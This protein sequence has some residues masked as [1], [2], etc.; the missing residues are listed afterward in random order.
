MNWCILI[1]AAVA[2]VFTI[3]I[4]YVIYDIWREGKDI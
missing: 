1:A 4:V 2:T 3:G